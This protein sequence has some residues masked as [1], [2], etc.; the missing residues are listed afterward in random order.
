VSGRR[1]RV[2]QWAT[3]NIG[4]R[5]LRG[6]IR[7]PDLELAGVVVFSR[8]KAG[9]DAGLLCGEEPVGVVA[10]AD[11]AVGRRIEADC[12]LY[13]PRVFD[14]DDVVALL[15]SGTN[16]VTTRGELF[17]SGHQLDDEGRARIIDACERGGASIYAT[18]SSPGFITDALPLALLSLQRRVESIEI[19]EYANMSQRDSPH[20]LFK[21]MKFGQPVA[22]F[23]PERAV[24][25]QKE[26]APP[27]ARLAAEANL[28]VDDWSCTGEVAVA[29]RTTQLVAGELPAGSVAAQRN[30]IVGTRGG[31]DV[32]RFTANWYCTTDVDPAWDLRPTGWRVRVHGDAPLDV[33][34]PFPVPLGDLGS[35]TPAYTANR[36]VNSIPYVCAAG[37]GIL[38]TTDLPPITPAGPRSTAGALR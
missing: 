36:P 6:V 18:G 23:D 35:F 5:S 28:T 33:Q 17:A 27:L 10:T 22:R 24:Y 25:L 11:R 8:E 38:S 15:E 29:T 4:G 26:F 14:L 2:V 16:V 12:A 32:I 34:V 9:V 21:Q 20:M 3:G 13:M 30:T 31:T 7:H 1:L 19:D 37:P